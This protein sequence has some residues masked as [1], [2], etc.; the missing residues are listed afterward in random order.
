MEELLYG[1]AGFLLALLLVFIFFKLNCHT[2]KVMLI[3][4][5]NNDPDN[6]YVLQFM[7]DPNNWLKGKYIWLKVIK[8]E[9][10]K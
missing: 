8:K 6:P 4:N 2:G 3:P 5:P 9:L 10:K 7:V 1:G